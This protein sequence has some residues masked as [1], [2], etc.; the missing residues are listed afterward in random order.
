MSKYNSNLNIII[1]STRFKNYSSKMQKKNMVG[2]YGYF[3]ANKH[4][5]ELT[6]PAQKQIGPP[7][8]ERSLG[9][10]RVASG[11]Y[12]SNN[13]ARSHNVSQ[14]RTAAGHHNQ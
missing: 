3:M 11:S 1:K 13:P 2:G 4:A 9:A 7:L 12:H 14:G 6:G 5:R 10:T 8:K